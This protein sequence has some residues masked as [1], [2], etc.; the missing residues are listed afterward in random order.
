M[1]YFYAVA[2]LLITGL[3]IC[4][5]FA[6]NE[7]SKQH[8]DRSWHRKY[9]S[10]YF[11]GISLF[12]ISS[13]LIHYLPIIDD[14]LIK[15]GY[16]FPGNDPSPNSPCHD[17]PP[18]TLALFY[19]NSASYATSFPY[20]VLEVKGQPKIILTKNERGG[21]GL[22]MNVFDKQEDIVAEIQD[23]EFTVNPRKI[24]KIKIKQDKTFLALIVEPR[25]EEIFSMTYLNPNAIKIK[26]VLHYPDTEERIV[27]TD[28]SVV[29]D[30]LTVQETCFHGNQ[31]GAV[32]IGDFRLN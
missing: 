31:G 11:L 27:I 9:R 23:N 13:V 4:S 29:L 7:W 15:H 22:T 10:S 19:G 24:F 14:R 6:L 32:Q 30:T 2:W 26:A 21:I 28:D 3:S 16:I 12:T 17:M 25:K 20:T 5:G 1:I 8:G 18:G